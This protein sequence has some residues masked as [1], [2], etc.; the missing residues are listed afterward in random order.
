M[1][2]LEKAAAMEN[3]MILFDGNELFNKIQEFRLN[4]CHI[5][6]RPTDGIVLT[7]RV[8]V[9][10]LRSPDLITPSNHGDAL[11]KQQGR[12]EISFLPFTKLLNGWIIRRSF[13]PA[14]PTI[15]VIGPIS[16]F[17]LI[18]FIMLL[19]VMPRLVVVRETLQRQIIL[20]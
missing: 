12:E 3:G 19:V 8:I 18:G 16:T 20:P 10:S 4:L 5:P 15:I 17:F 2:A 6:I 1:L 14:I 9:S 11:R 13:Y 7:I